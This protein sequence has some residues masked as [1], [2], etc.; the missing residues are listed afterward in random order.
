MSYSLP[1]VKPAARHG[2]DWTR[3]RRVSVTGVIVKSFDVSDLARQAAILLRW[4]A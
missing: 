1:I 4:P 3:F 2:L